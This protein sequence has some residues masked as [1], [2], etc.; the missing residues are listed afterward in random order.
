MKLPRIAYIAIAGI[1]LYLALQLPHRQSESICEAA[2]NLDRISC[3]QNIILT[4][5]DG[6]KSQTNK[7]AGFD[8]FKQKDF[9]K[10]FELLNKDWQL[11]KDP[12]TLLALS[13]AKILRDRPANVKTIAVVIPR[14]G[15]PK[16]VA[17]NILK[18]V[19]AAQQEW[20]EK[21]NGWKLLVAIA[22]DSN[23]PQVG[24]KIAEELVKH[25]DILAVLGHYSST[26]TVS[27]KDIYQQAKTVLLSATSTSDELTQDPEN[28][29]NYFFR[30]L[31]STQVSA[32]H[33]AQKWRSQPGKIV[34]FYTPN[35]KFSGSFRKAFFT[36]VP[37]SNIVRE[38]DLSNR[39]NAA[40]E[41]ALAKAAGATTIVIIPDAFTDANELER[42]FAVIKVNQGQMPILGTSIVRDA[43]LFKF[44]SA[45][46]KNLVVTIPVHP[47]DRRF[48]DQMRLNQAPDWWGAKDQI[49]DRIINSYDAMQ[50]LLAALDKST[51]R[52]TVRP[53]IASPRFSVW[54]IT[55]KISFHGSERAEKIDSLVSPTSCDDYKCNFHVVN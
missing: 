1:C 49:H 4:P 29:N 26:V 24:K 41:L 37:S 16:F 53:T 8:A 31:G 35:K 3:G 42:L 50:V 18:G 21:N 9:S 22:D 11:T 12:E 47:T 6:G 25:Q 33:L 14:S 43:Y 7:V 40:Q 39:H 2:N 34:L 45:Q 38:F 44:S 19:A 52:S 5:A 51:D 23:D 30:V 54:G 36:Y 15:A 10:A 55:G 20:N 13:N 28:P 27:V 48:I 46:L 17:A 32:E